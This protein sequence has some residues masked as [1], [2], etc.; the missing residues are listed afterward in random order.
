LLFWQ[1]IDSQTRTPAHLTIW[2]FRR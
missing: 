1:Q 2:A